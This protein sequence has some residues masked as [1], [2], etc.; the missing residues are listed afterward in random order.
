M[1]CLLFS[2]GVGESAGEDRPNIVFL[3]ADDQRVDTIAAHGNSN[4]QTPNLD[5]LTREGVSCRQNYCAGSYS[6]AV[7]VASRSMI[8]TGRHWMRID[9]TR[10][11]TGLPLLPEV[12]GKNGYAT[13]AV[14]KWHNGLSTLTRGFQSGKAIMMGG[15]CDHTRVPLQDLTGEGAL[16]N[17]R[18]GEGFSST[19]F[20]DAAIDFLVTQEKSANPFFLYVAF[21]APHDP[22][23]PP[24][25][26]RQVYYDDPPPLPENF[27]PQHPF[28][29][30]QVSRGGR[31]EGL[32]DWPRRPEVIRDQLCEYYGL[33]THLDEQVGRILNA[34]DELGFDEKTIVV[35]AADHGLALG[36]HGLLGKQNVYEHS[37]SCP[38]VVRGPGIPKNTSTMAMT[39]LL[40]LYR[41]LCGYAG[42]EVP[43]GVDGHNL[44]SVFE[45]TQESVRSSV[46]L[47]YQDKMRTIR[48]KD[49]KLHVYPE[50]NYRLLFDLEAD[51]L[52][53]TNLAEDPARAS[54]IDRLLGEMKAW[55]QRLGDTLPLTVETPLQKEIDLTGRARL[56]DR[57]QPKWIRD[58]YFGGR[59]APDLQRTPAKKG[60]EKK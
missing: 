15:M 45:G 47:A 13:H 6:G 35:Y 33:V 43:E 54:D 39:Y 29:N 42:V 18:V 37:M 19:L 25:S 52:E 46:F 57:W 2:A 9:D 60:N 21:T 8:M 50:I 16:A 22:R 27:L 5:R 31:D 58:K 30:G 1:L 14:G 41:T 40:D 10:N 56:P 23:N 3:F 34:I 20:A 17:S 48:H 53:M 51:P 28:N 55:Q 12:L 26:Y 32:A 49:L 11:W 36:S 24:E 4:I 59:E 7:C 44:R 38:L